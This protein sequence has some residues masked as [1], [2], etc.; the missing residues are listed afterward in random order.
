MASSGIW[1]A[2]AA[3]AAGAVLWRLGRPRRTEAGRSGQSGIPSQ[4]R[5]QPARVT[6][7]NRRPSGTAARRRPAGWR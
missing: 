1:A 5:L 2:L 3:L 4:L 6:E 7:T